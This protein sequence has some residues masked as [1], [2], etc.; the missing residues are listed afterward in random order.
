MAIQIVILFLL[1]LGLPFVRGTSSKKNLMWHGYSTLAALILHTILIFFI[2]VPSL[3]GDFG[4]LSELSLFDSFTVWS[5][6]VL[7]TAAEV[8][9]I[10][11][12]A[13]WLLS[14]PANLKCNK[15]KRGG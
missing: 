12:V 14:G 8:L 15:W 11:L 10:I 2:M 9:A 6:A 13:P 7:G 3:A 4:E 5:H 1:V